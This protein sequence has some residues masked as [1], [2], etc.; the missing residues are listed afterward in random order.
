MKLILFKEEALLDSHSRWFSDYTM[1]L[2]L[3]TEILPDEMDLDIMSK[4]MSLLGGY[5]DE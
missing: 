2:R 4:T 3:E 5:Y 1:M